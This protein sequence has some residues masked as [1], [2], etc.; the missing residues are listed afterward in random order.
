MKATGMFVILMIQ[1]GFES[2]FPKT[3]Q[4]AKVINCPEVHRVTVDSY[5]QSNDEVSAFPYA[6]GS[7]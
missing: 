2:D 7:N 1:D 5:F 4:F 6:V 3:S